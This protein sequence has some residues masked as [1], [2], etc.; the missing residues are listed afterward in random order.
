MLDRLKGYKDAVKKKNIGEYVLKVGY[1][2]TKDNNIDTVKR[3]IEN[4]PQLDAIF[5]A[6]NYLTFT[7][8]QVIK[9]KGLSIPT[10]LAVVSFD[11]NR[12]FE[13]HA[14]SISAVAQ[15]VEEIS[16]EIIKQLKLR[17][18]SDDKKIKDETVVFQPRLLMRESSLPKSS[19]QPPF[20]VT[21]KNRKMKTAKST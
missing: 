17:L 13:I 11:D 12:Y 2:L 10:D 16:H 5:F 3:F 15:P 6:T 14:P 9:N 8:L 21:Q 7:G 4:N 19:I 1:S 20:S 18:N